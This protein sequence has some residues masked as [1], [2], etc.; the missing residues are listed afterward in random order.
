LKD[1]QANDLIQV[2]VFHR[3]ELRTY[4]ITLA[5]AIPGK[6]QLKSVENPSSRE[7]ENFVG[8][9]GVPLSTIQ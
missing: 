6:Y 9:L 5:V 1:Y 4:S 8:W 2:T 3:D 7:M